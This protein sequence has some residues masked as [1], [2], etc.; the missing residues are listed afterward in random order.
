MITYKD[1][2]IAIN[3]QLSKT[4]IEI[5]SRDVTEGFNRPS[6]FVQLNNVGRSGDVSQV[7]KAMTVQIYYFPTDRYEYSIEALEMQETLEELFDLKL[8][9]RDRHLNVD[10]LNTFINDGVLNC[11]F[12][13]AFYSGRKTEYEIIDKADDGEEFREKYPIEQMEELDY[14]KK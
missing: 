6:F 3:R 11:T 4:G 9:V 12:D 2:R 7:H 13:L 14:E 1:I 8:S 5:T 10:E